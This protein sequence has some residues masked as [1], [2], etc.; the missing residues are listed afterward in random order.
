MADSFHKYRIFKL[1]HLLWLLAVIFSGKEAS[2]QTGIINKD[3]SVCKNSQVQL[4]AEPAFSY[5]WSPANTF[6]DPSIQN[7]VIKADSSRKYYLK[8]SVISNN[9]VRNGDFEN[10]NSDFITNYTYCN[11][12]NC[13][14]PLADNGYSIGKDASF[15]HNLFVG[16]DHTTGKGNFMII[17]GANPAL[18]VWQQTIAVKPNT[19]YAFGT[20]I[21]SLINLNTAQI[22]FSING[23]QLGPIYNAPTNLQQW[24]RFFISWNSG[25]QTTAVIEIVD[26]LPQPNGND[27]GL[28]DIFFG[29]VITE[30]DSIQVDVEAGKPLFTQ[31][32]IGLC[33]ESVELDAGPG[34]DQYLWS[35]GA[36]SRKISVSKTGPY[37]VLA[38]LV[39]GCSITDTVIVKNSLKMTTRPLVGCGDELVLLNNG[40]VESV[41]GKVIEFFSDSARTYQLNSSVKISTRFSKQGKFN[42]AIEYKNY[43][44]GLVNS[45]P[46]AGYGDTYL[47]VYRIV[48]NN[49]IFN[50]PQNDI[51][52]KYTIRFFATVTGTYQF[53]T[54]F[55]FG[56][57]GAI[58]LDGNI[59]AFNNA[60]MWWNGN[61]DLAGQSLQWST[62]LAI[63][64]HEI[65][66]Y[67]LEDCCDGGGSAE[68]KA[69][70]ET[71]YHPFSTLAYVKEVGTYYVSLHDP[72]TGCSNKGSIKVTRSPRPSIS[73]KNPDPVCK[74]ATIDLTLASLTE[75]S[76]AP[77]NFNYFKNKEL[78]VRVLDPASI[79]DSGTY[80]I[81]GQAPNNCYTETKEVLVNIYST[82]VASFSTAQKTGCTNQTMAF[83]NTTPVDQLFRFHWEF[84]TGNAKDTSNQANPIFSYTTPGLYRVTFT[85]FS[86][87]GCYSLVTD[88]IRIFEK[89]EM[90]INGPQQVCIGSLV[91]FR[92]STSDPAL[93]NLKWIFN[94]GNQSDVLQPP[95]QQYLIAGNYTI[96]LIGGS[97]TCTDTA[98]LQLTVKAGPVIGLATREARICLGAS[99]QLSANDGIKYE[100]SPS[101]GLNNPGISN[102]IASPLTDTR[103]IV[104]VTSAIG[105]TGIDSVQISVNQPISINA[106]GDDHICDGDELQLQANGA[107]RYEWMPAT[108]L[109]NPNIS[110][111]I[112]RPNISTE[113]QVI[114]FG[115]DNCFSD[116][117]RVNVH[118][119]ALPAVVAGNDTT[120]KAGTSLQLKIKA[121]SDVNQYSWSPPTSLSCSKCPQPVAMPNSATTYTITVQNEAGCLAMDEIEVRLNCS[122]DNVYIPNA[123]TPNNDGINEYFYPMGKGVRSIKFFRIFNR[124]GQ[125]VFERK[126]IAINDRS[127]G[128]DG[129]YKGQNLPSG[130]F[131]YSLQ[132]VCDSGQF[133][134]L[135]GNVTL[136]R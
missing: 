7:P 54:S 100:W 75:G 62:N 119:D 121:S 98:A 28:D 50:G 81:V 44:D 14:F 11:T 125:L 65:Q 32:S 80:F 86:P 33:N 108:G 135:K 25:S 26:V 106:G 35:T 77:M 3:T 94:N 102:P 95:A 17:N 27:F 91:E 64:M 5:S 43:I 31:D 112:A 88:T 49:I 123:F 104:K 118:V 110:N 2:A 22:R 114:G 61:W 120:I 92:G 58:F 71:E 76:D 48:S 70:G 84:G 93:N 60:D 56:K 107:V 6:S 63:G 57:G 85:V 74:P 89:P 8:R 130:E 39:S 111:P 90:A 69:P 15:P 41:R 134:D 128:W 129:R 133:I 51:A 124:F 97:S 117:A 83:R 55:D 131:V 72:V 18:I 40:V 47:P 36:T 73:V 29:E 4:F 101:V 116:T 99:L 10:W 109:S 34:F 46:S 30:T 1:V 87:G 16:K 126:D 23:T 13:L 20:W 52:Y 127:A 132:V 12:G 105:C 82:P 79:T 136:L 19:Q 53:R 115:I 24:D 37:H 67:G 38:S 66:I 103:Y 42:T 96:Q 45:P 78:T 59:A 68:Y 113:Y 21:S 122:S 9:L